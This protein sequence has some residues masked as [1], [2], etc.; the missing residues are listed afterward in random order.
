MSNPRRLKLTKRPTLDKDLEFEIFVFETLV[1][2]MRG[3]YERLLL[4][5]K[6]FS[7]KNSAAEV[8]VRVCDRHMIAL[9]FSPRNEEFVW[10][11]IVILA[12][13]IEEVSLQISSRFRTKDKPSRSIPVQKFADIP[14]ALDHL[15]HWLLETFTIGD[16]DS[17]NH[18]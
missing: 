13:K 6:S 16:T 7:S 17:T 9:V 12:G 4:Y 18:W 14:T 1:R 10:V 2:E 3:A 8:R 15:D 5:R 11:S